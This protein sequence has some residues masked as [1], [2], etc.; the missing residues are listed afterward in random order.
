MRIRVF[1]DR[2]TMGGA[3]AVHAAGVLRRAIAKRGRARFIAATGTSQFEFLQALVAEPGVDW[4]HVELFHLDEYLGLPDTHP[5]SFCRYLR[6]RLIEPAGIREY[7]LLDGTADP[8]ELMA[9]VGRALNESPVDLACVGVG[10]NGHL[11]FN[12]PPADFKTEAPFLV[13]ALDERSRRQQV[14][15][16]WFARM[17][18][19]PARAITMSVRQI[20][21]ADEII[22]LA[23]DARKAEAVRA[24][25]G[26][27]VRP[28]A[29][30]SALLDHPRSTVYL[31]AAAAALLPPDA[32]E[33]GA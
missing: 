18:Q 27:G 25:F 29:P 23:P 9:R 5:A 6:E 16:G 8:G 11:A 13:V 20:L 22:C 31:D 1:P 28:E 12:E 19:V 26:N 15:E 30:A 3:G 24:C 2:K 10:E 7:H 21:M 33:R 32:L 17:D 14:D 4:A